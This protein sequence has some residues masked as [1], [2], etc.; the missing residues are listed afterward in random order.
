MAFNSILKKALVSACY[1]F[2]VIILAYALIGICFVDGMGLE[3][4]SVFLLYPLSFGFALANSILKCTTLKSGLKLISHFAI[5]T[6]SLI[7]FVYV[8][9]SRLISAGTGMIIFA[10]Y[11]LIY[12]IFA[13][14]YS[15]VI[16]K[17]QKIKDKNED[18]KKVY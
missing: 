12:V 1:A 15:F 9:R 5:I 4:R 13:A 6:L 7:L 11:V 16:S 17:K 18:Y 10:L 2:S 8:P 3:P 14:I